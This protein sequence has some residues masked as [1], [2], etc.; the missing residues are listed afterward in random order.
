[1]GSDDGNL[2]DKSI[3][4][5]FLRLARGSGAY[6]QKS[7]IRINI[8]KSAVNTAHILYEIDNLV[9]IT[10][11]IV[12]QAISLTKRSLSMIPARASK[13]QVCVSPR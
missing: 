11:L 13:M 6:G 1:M 2:W 9:R 10:Y 3:S 12:L 4:R 7:E 8:Q 5:G